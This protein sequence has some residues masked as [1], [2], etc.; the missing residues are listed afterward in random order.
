MRIFAVL[1]QRIH[2]LTD[3]RITTN[4]ITL[5]S[6]DNNCCIAAALQLTSCQSIKIICSISAVDICHW[7]LRCSQT[8]RIDSCVIFR[9]FFC[10]YFYSVFHLQYSLNLFSKK[11][12]TTSCRLL[13][14]LPQVHLRADEGVCVVIVIYNMCCQRIY[15]CHCSCDELLVTGKCLLINT[16]MRGK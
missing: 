8:E 15:C 1:Q 11:K 4:P 13:P 2:S 10:C 9:P 5:V 12:K 14:Y 16:K 3:N 7:I 6:T